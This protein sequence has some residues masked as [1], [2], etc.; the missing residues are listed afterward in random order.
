MYLY[1]TSGCNVLAAFK[2]ML[3]AFKALARRLARIR[4]RANDFYEPTKERKMNKFRI[5]AM[6]VVLTLVL[7]VLAAF[8]TPAQAN[9][10][11]AS[12]SGNSQLEIENMFG[13]ELIDVR[14][15]AFQVKELADGTV[16]G[17][18]VHRSLDDGVPFHVSGPLTCLNVQGNRAWV[19]GFIDASSDP[20]L[21]GAEMWFQVQDN[22]E[23]TR[24]DPDWTTLIGASFEE[25]SAQEYC[26][27]AP[28]VNF[29]FDIEHGN[30]QV[31][32]RD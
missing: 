22:G 7:L 21:V 29:P 5:S 17:S 2:R 13:L 10:V 26:D 25:G 18:Y 20:G 12:A 15:Y 1:M 16:Q 3:P 4:L 30:I 27:D 6:I 23:G 14:V 11:V 32:P 28:E 8:V 31:R 9:A 24:G 19:G